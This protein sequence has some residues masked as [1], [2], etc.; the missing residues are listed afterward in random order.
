MATRPVKCRPGNQHKTWLT[1]IQALRKAEQYEMTAY[2]CYDHWHIGHR[3]PTR[4][5]K[6]S[7]LPSKGENQTYATTPGERVARR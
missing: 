3:R 1:K 7:D 6:R 2:G 4:P 5:E